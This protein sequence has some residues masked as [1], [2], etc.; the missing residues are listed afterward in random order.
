MYDES[1]VEL[2]AT[3]E[4]WWD[5]S[6]F[7][8]T[9]FHATPVEMPAWFAL[10]CYRKSEVLV[11]GMKEPISLIGAMRSPEWPKWKEA[12]EQEIMGLLMMGL[13][14]EVP[15]TSVPSGYNVNSGHFVF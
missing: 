12:I 15:R 6:Y 8:S 11:A 14:Q 3:A 7:N 2:F 5:T 10:A 13:W 9:Q 1:D 4:A